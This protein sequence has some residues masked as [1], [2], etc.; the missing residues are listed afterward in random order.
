MEHVVRWEITVE[1]DT[2]REAAEK[3]RASQLR[4]DTTAT[5]FDVYTVDQ[6]G[7]PV[8]GMPVEV[9]L[10]DQC[11]CRCREGRHCG[12]CGHA[13]CGYRP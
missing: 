3:A 11:E 12:G 1:A 9:D 10:Y 4:P 5:V 2:P 8:P 7:N 13:G 6:H